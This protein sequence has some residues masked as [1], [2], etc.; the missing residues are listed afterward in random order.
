MMFFLRNSAPSDLQ[1]LLLSAARAVNLIWEW[2]DDTR[3]YKRLRDAL[4]QHSTVPWEYV[5]KADLRGD[6]ISSNETARR[7][8]PIRI[9]VAY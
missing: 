9:F 8:A 1:V 2:Y 5:V 7:Q 3:I 4:R 6:D